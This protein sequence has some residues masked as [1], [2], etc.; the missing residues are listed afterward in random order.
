MQHG[1]SIRLVLG[2]ACS[3]RAGEPGGQRC[4]Q[5]QLASVRAP[6]GGR[7]AVGGREDA[8]QQLPG[9]ALC[10]AHLSTLQKHAAAF[11]SYAGA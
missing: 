8:L 5:G 6:Q 11:F 2:H 9:N 4:R 7:A 10:R 1:D 3:G